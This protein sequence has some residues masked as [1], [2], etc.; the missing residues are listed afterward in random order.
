MPIVLEFRNQSN[1][2]SQLVKPSLQPGLTWLGTSLAC[3]VHW[4]QQKCKFSLSYW[5]FS[6]ILNCKSVHVPKLGLAAFHPFYHIVSLNCNE[7][8]CTEGERGEGGDLWLQLV[9]SSD[10]EA[11]FGF[12]L[13]IWTLLRISLYFLYNW[14]TDWGCWVI[15][16]LVN[17]V[18]PAPRRGTEMP[19]HISYLF[20]IESFCWYKNRDNVVGTFYVLWE[21]YNRCQTVLWLELISCN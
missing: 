15:V 11:L 10:R 17:W 19:S 7:L 16:C 9:I 21:I 3:H 12:F 1:F 2:L 6:L 13:Y 5:V 14:K 4:M 18:C 8:I 20:S